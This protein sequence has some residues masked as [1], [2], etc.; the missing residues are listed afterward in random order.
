MD[1]VQ[2]FGATK[3][4]DRMHKMYTTRA[5]GFLLCSVLHQFNH[6]SNVLCTVQRLVSPYLC[7]DFNVQMA[8]AKSRSNDTRCVQLKQ[9]NNK[10]CI[11]SVHFFFIWFWNTEK[12]TTGK[13]NA[14]SNRHK[15][16]HG[17][18]QLQ[19]NNLKKTHTFTKT[20]KQKQSATT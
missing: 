13:K 15:V 16:S 6:K 5:V 14:P 20:R 4:I 12:K 10:P 1:T 8:Y 19:L 7:S 2:Y 18:H 3:T 17:L 11:L 9:Q